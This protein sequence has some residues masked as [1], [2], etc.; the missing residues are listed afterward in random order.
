MRYFHNNMHSLSSLY[1]VLSSLYVVVLS[2]YKVKFLHYLWC[3][4]CH[5]YTKCFWHYM[6][7]VPLKYCLRE[8]YCESISFWQISSLLC[9]NYTKAFP[10]TQR[11]GNLPATCA[12]RKA[13]LLM[14]IYLKTE[15]QQK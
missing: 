1:A 11:E 9:K 15:Q 8:N 13:K 4:V 2:L 12:G 10:W 14:E 7:C 6:W 5:H 3:S